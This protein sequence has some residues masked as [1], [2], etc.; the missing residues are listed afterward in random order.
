M[1]VHKIYF[2]FN[3]V[4]IACLSKYPDPSKKEILSVDYISREYDKNEEKIKITRLITMQWYW[5]NNIYFVE[6]INIW[7]TKMTMMAS[8]IS[9]EDKIKIRENCHYKKIDDKST[10]LRQDVRFDGINNYLSKKISNIYLES[11]E[12]G[13]NILHERLKNLN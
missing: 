12:N 1:I 8:N 7:K 13:I 6:E 9:W 11:G 5:C 3:K 10:L 4:V 2:P